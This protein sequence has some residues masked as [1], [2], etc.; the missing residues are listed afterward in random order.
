MLIIKF[1]QSSPISIF[2]KCSCAWVVGRVCLCIH[3]HHITILTKD[4]RTASNANIAQY[5][6]QDTSTKITKAF[7]I[8]PTHSRS[9]YSMYLRPLKEASRT[10]YRYGTPPQHRVLW[11]LS[12][13]MHA[14]VFI[15]Q[16][17]I[18]FELLLQAVSGGG[19]GWGRVCAQ[20]QT[21][22]SSESNANFLLSAASRPAYFPSLW[23]VRCTTYVQR[24]ENQV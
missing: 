2:S 17:K 9:T 14:R 10:L 22:H 20:K 19:G 15:P 7:S 8:H 11:Y 12:W 3:T 4:T 16:A 18:Y 13:Q 24:P 6:E 23:T 1:E 5:S 21:N